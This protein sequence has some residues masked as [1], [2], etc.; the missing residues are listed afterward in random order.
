MEFY[1]A[2]L[3]ILVTANIYLLYRQHTKGRRDTESQLADLENHESPHIYAVYKFEKGIPENTVAAI[4]S[5][6]VLFFGRVCGGVCTT[7]LFS[8]FETWMISEYHERCL[9][10]VGLR[11]S[12]VFG[13]LTT[14]SYMVAIVSTF[15]G[16]LLIQ[17]SRT[18]SA[19][20]LAASV[21]CV[22]AA[23][24]IARFWNENFGAQ[25]TEGTLI[26]DVKKDILAMIRKPRIFALGVTSCFLEGTVYLFLFYWSEALKSTRMRAGPASGDP[27]FMLVLYSFMC[28]T[29]IGSLIYTLLTAAQTLQ[30]AFNVIM[31][32]TLVASCCLSLGAVL[33]T[34]S[35]LFWALCLFEVCV[36]AYL[37]SMAYL[38]SEVVEDGVRGRMYNLLRFPINVFVLVAYGLDE[39]GDAQ[40][41]RV[42]FV[43]SG[44]LLVAFLVARRNF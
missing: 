27:P 44:L 40:R 13:N 20:F 19:P 38:K 35:L 25:Q 2:N 1:R 14:I 24:L 12:S 32:V 5:L 43:C 39:E 11:L 10:L 4:N 9:P 26:E 42:F 29:M 28:A 8:V 3:A 17:H 6:L 18:Q 31:A 37:P 21:C 7:L 41:N 16:D 34:E 23:Y 15:A 30:G 33:Q 36:G 22:G